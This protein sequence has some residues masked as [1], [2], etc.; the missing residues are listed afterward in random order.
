MAADRHGPLFF[1]GNG[2]SHPDRLMN[3]FRLI[4]FVLFAP[5]SHTPQSLFRVSIRSALASE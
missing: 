5:F 4:V 3:S 1:S 2:C